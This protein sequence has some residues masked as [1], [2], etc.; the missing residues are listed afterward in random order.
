[1]QGDRHLGLSKGIK[2]L[3]LENLNNQKVIATSKDNFF[4]SRPAKTYFA[5]CT[6]PSYQCF[7]GGW[8][9]GRFLAIIL[10]L[11]Q[12]VEGA[13]LSYIWTRIY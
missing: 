2:A 11:L 13:Y 6:F 9:K 8:S 4:V 10:S 12:C 5:S 1:M 3:K 7:D